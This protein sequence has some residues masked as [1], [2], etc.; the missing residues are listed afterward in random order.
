MHDTATLDDA[1][2]RSD[3][4]AASDTLARVIR[5]RRTAKLMSDPA[6]R[7]AEHDGDWTEAH[8]AALETMI[9]HAGAAPFH[10]RAHEATHRQGSTGSPVPWRFHVLGRADC[11]CLVDVLER[12]AGAR[13]DSEWSRAWQS[14]IGA[15]LCACG[16][17]VQATWLPDPSGATGDEA[18]ND[19][20]TND[21]ATNEGA[22]ES[23]AAFT[24]GNVE[25][26]AAASAAVQN[27]LLLA[28]ARGWRSYWS[29]GGILRHE[30]LLALLGIGAEERL[31]GS[32]FLA[33][34]EM[35]CE[36][37][38]RGGLREERGGADGWSRWVDVTP[39]AG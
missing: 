35:P 29:S 20:A 37:L 13:P 2:T 28:T 19:G 32:I 31:L 10:R 6:R 9:D 11:R 34:P 27:L 22:A 8:R 3:H 18:S 1:T 38:V 30:E 16:A 36:R 7:A 5:E 26:V 23:E 21:G 33:P 12:R 17:L 15:M 4:E 39:S 24:L 25:H 14:K